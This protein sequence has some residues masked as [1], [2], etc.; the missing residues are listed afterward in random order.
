MEKEQIEDAYNRGKKEHNVSSK[1]ISKTWGF[2]G[3][4]ENNNN[5][6]RNRSW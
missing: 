3:E 2:L 5:E 4:E 6:R 1:P